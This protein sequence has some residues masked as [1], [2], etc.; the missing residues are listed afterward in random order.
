MPSNWMVV[1]G[2]FAAAASATSHGDTLAAVL[3]ASA[4]R[5]RGQASPGNEST[6]CLAIH[7]LLD[8]ISL[9]HAFSCRCHFAVFLTRPKSGSGSRVRRISEI[10]LVPMGPCILPDSR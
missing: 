1:A 2:A 9:P 5:P 4:H 6:H 3:Q 8:A 7:S 10:G